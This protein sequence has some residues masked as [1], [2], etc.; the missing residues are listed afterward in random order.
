[1]IRGRHTIGT[2]RF[3]VLVIFALIA[4]IGTYLVTVGDSDPSTGF[5]EADVLASPDA[6]GIRI[7]LK[8]VKATAEKHIFAITMPRDLARDLCVTLPTGFYEEQLHLERLLP[9]DLHDRAVRIESVAE[10]NNDASTMIPEFRDDGY[11][12]E[13]VHL[14]T[15]AEVTFRFGTDT[16]RRRRLAL[17]LR[18]WIELVACDQRQTTIRRRQLCYFQT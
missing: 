12:P 17:R 9:P 3:L 7:E 15:D 5:V 1:M 11:L 10:F 8:L 2:E 6:T 13:G 16:P 4:A 18:R 14:A